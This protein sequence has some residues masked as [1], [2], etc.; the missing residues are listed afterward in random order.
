MTLVLTTDE[1]NNDIIKLECDSI[2]G[3]GSMYVTKTSFVLESDNNN[4]I[5]F[6][7]LH[8]QIY[9]LKALSNQKAEI[10]W[11]EDGD[12]QKFAFRL[13]DALSHVKQIVEEQNYENNFIDLLANNI[14]NIS[15][16]EKTR[17]TEK[18]L[19]FCKKNITQYKSLLTKAN[20]NIS[21]LDENDNNFNQN[22]SDGLQNLTDTNKTLSMWNQY[23]ND[24]Y[25]TEI[26]R[27]INIPAEIPNHLCWFDCWYDDKTQCYITFNTKFLEPYSF[28]TIDESVKKFNNETTIPNVCA[29]PKKYVEFVNGYPA[30][31]SKYVKELFSDKTKQ[32]ETPSIIIPSMTDEM[33]NDDLIS[34]WH[35]ISIQQDLEIESYPQIPV[36]VYYYTSK[37]SRIILTNKIRC[38]YSQKERV[39]LEHRDVFPEK[40]KPFLP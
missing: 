6:Q 19:S 39:F 3:R 13:P 23:R 29:I 35:G 20:D 36:S 37:G 24:I 12:I 27:H 21:S 25:K 28:D 14:T 34:K 32:G 31:K 33:L 9:S 17:I 38:R 5:Y 8:T 16:K 7:R 22:S 2:F 26:N 4:L 18:R 10:T 1:K 15:D 40:H 11:V 30:I